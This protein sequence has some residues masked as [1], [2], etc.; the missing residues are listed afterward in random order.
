[1]HFSRFA[2]VIITSTMGEKT[3]FR[4]IPV[5]FVLKGG[6][7]FTQLFTKWYL[8]KFWEK[9]NPLNTFVSK[10]AMAIVTSATCEK[11]MNIP[12]ESS[13]PFLR[14]V[15]HFG[16]FLGK[17]GVFP[18]ATSQFS[19]LCIS[20]LSRSFSCVSH[21]HFWP[22]FFHLLFITTTSSLRTTTRHFQAFLCSFVS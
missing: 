21:H 5:F 13:A 9:K 22:H 15:L 2:G 1:M 20:F 18:P 8:N 19:C 10:S 3:N 12:C 14:T 17:K 16:P 11:T 6:S 7:E 4:A